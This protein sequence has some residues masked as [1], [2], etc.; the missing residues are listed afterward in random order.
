MS[1]LSECHVA[2][3]CALCFLHPCASYPGTLVAPLRLSLKPHSLVSASNDSPNDWVDRSSFPESELL[4]HTVRPHAY[5]S[6]KVVASARDGEPEALL[7]MATTIEMSLQGYTTFPHILLSTWGDVN[8]TSGTLGTLVFTEVVKDPSATCTPDFIRSKAVAICEASCRFL[9]NPDLIRSV[10]AAAGI[11]VV[12]ANWM[13]HDERLNFRSEVIPE[14]SKICKHLQGLFEST[15]SSSPDAEVTTE[16]IL[17]TA[18]TMIQ[19]TSAFAE[20]GDWAF[21]SRDSNVVGLFFTM[22]ERGSRVDE[23]NPLTMVM[24]ASGIQN[25]K[26]EADTQSS[27]AWKSALRR[28]F[29]DGSHCALSFIRA[30]RRQRLNHSSS[31]LGFVLHAGILRR[32]F[33]ALGQLSDEEHLQFPDVREAFRA[34]GIIEEITLLIAHIING[35]FQGAAASEELDTTPNAIALS[36]HY[37]FQYMGLRLKSY[38]GELWA[39]AALSKGL[40]AHLISLEKFL[41][42]KASGFDIGHGNVLDQ[43]LSLARGVRVFDVVATEL[44][45]VWQDEDSDH[46]SCVWQLFENE[47][48]KLALARRLQEKHRSPFELACTNV[49]LL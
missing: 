15:T 22:W 7:A 49:S 40:L 11:M 38:D 45:S 19:A 27:E 43:L 4:P 16:N 10:Q 47:F 21:L 31:G 46:A 23:Q 33:N 13:T 14:M 1:H 44:L 25:L 6:I 5:P 9:K 48:I 36:F 17:L 30:L 20:E 42:S 18:L 34:N 39:H 41:S 3:R 32:V 2:S 8:P 29:T 37:C 28:A 35:L 24:P 12:S 26:F